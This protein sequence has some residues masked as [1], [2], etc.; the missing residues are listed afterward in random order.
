MKHG[1]MTL[2]L[3]QIVILSSIA[4]VF[5]ATPTLSVAK[6]NL[7]ASVAADSEAKWDFDS[8]EDWNRIVSPLDDSDELIIGL[9]TYPDSYAELASLVQQWGGEL[10]NT[11]RGGGKI[12]AI[13]V[14]GSSGAMSSLSTRVQATGLSR[15]V[16]PNFKVSACWEPNDPYWANGSQWGP[17][18][19]E[20]NYAWN[21]TKG[22]HRILVAVIDTGIDYNHTDLRNNYAFDDQGNP[23]GYDWANNDT[24]PMDDNGHGTYCA[25]IIAAVQNNSVGIA[26]VA[27]VTI[28]AEK[29]LDQD[30]YGW[31]DD[32]ANGIYHAIDELE[33]D[34]LSLSLG[35]SIHN[36]T[37]YLEFLSS[38]TF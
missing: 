3:I 11:I 36:V 23:L 6:G 37:F 16:E 10:V 30:G 17:K 35:S 26:G 28:V 5:L 33:A 8:P 12:R 27:N 25:G 15:Y 9:R 20:A 2:I 14:N 7:P 32:I 18:K 22:D 1:S 24:D 21:E 38:K 29:V 19:I 34:I 13:V 4:I 31:A